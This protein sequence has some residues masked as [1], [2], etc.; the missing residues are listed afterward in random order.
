MS[1]KDFL[2]FIGIMLLALGFAYSCKS[3]GPAQKDKNTAA[4][5]AA[6]ISIK[7]EYAAPDRL[8]FSIDSGHVKNKV[9]SLFVR[10]YGGCKNHDFQ[11]V[12]T[13]YI[14]KSLPPQTEL[15][16]VHDTK[17]DSCY[18]PLEKVINFNL[19]KLEASEF[20]DIILDVNHLVYINYQPN[21]QTPTNQSQ[22]KKK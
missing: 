13:N 1:P 7:P 11:L 4:V 12:A 18:R 9:L 20:E 2:Q 22:P 15:F 5:E 6:E 17:G 21:K 19:S 16:L 3:G 10:Y 8:D 14:K